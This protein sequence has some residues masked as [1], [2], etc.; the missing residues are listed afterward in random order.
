MFCQQQ[1]FSDRE[2]ICK[3]NSHFPDRVIKAL[4]LIG[5][6]PKKSLPCNNEVVIIFLSRVKY[7]ICPKQSKISICFR[8]L[9]KAFHSL[10]KCNLKNKKVFIVR[11]QANKPKIKDPASF[12]NVQVSWTVPR[13]LWCNKMG[14]LIHKANLTPIYS[15]IQSLSIWI[16]T[17]H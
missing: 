14:A 8:I 2:T 3:N 17:E 9:N 10:P 4:R 13:R 15:L 11:Y 5:N 6:I 7:Y 12:I 16:K 1:F